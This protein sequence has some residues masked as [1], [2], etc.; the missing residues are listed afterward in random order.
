MMDSAVY[1]VNVSLD[2]KMKPADEQRMENWLRTRLSRK[3][4]KVVVDYEGQ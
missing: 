1:V 3:D 2:S 4:V